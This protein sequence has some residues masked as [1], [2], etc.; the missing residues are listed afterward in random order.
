MTTARRLLQSN[1][2]FDGTAKVR[3]VARQQQVRAVALMP[4][5][6]KPL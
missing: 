5:K 1:L 4:S 6:R 2:T 3:K